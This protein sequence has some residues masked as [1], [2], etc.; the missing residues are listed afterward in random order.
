[1]SDD[2]PL[3]P[4]TLQELRRADGED[5]P[6]YVAYKGIVYDLSGCP[7]WRQGLHEQQH[8][9]AQD[10]TGELTGAPHGEEVFKRPCVRVVGVLVNP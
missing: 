2:Q 3:T 4:V 1:M 5:G 10:L 6:M 7:R 8:F 9:P